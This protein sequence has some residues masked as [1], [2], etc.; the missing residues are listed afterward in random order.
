MGAGLGDR[1]GRGW[2][3][4]RCSVILSLLCI[5]H[6]EDPGSFCYRTSYAILAAN[7]LPLPFRQKSC[8]PLKISICC[9]AQKCSD[10]YNHRQERGWEGRGEINKEA[11]VLHSLYRID[12]KQ[13]TPALILSLTSQ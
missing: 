7:P 5:V 4:V 8:S 12:I 6:R 9:C 11:L 2:P 3:G 1:G 13:E 10:G